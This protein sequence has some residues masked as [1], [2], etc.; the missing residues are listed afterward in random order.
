MDILVGYKVANPASTQGS[1]SS[2]GRRTPMRQPKKQNI[3]KLEYDFNE[4]SIP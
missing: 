1:R 4:S 2:D 3:N